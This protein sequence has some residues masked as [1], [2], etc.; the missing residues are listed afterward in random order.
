MQGPEINFSNI[1]AVQESLPTLLSRAEFRE[2]GFIKVLVEY[3]LS[4]EI[5]L[6]CETLEFIL[7]LF[8]DLD[9]PIEFFHSGGMKLLMESDKFVDDE[10]NENEGYDI[11]IYELIDLV[12]DVLQ[13]RGVLEAANSILSSPQ[14]LSHFS[15]QFPNLSNSSSI[16]DTEEN[17]LNIL[18]DDNGVSNDESIDLIL[19]FEPSR[20]EG[21]NHVGF[22]EWPSSFILRS[23]IPSL[24]FFKEQLSHHDNSISNRII[25]DE[26]GECCCEA[27]N[28]RILELGSGVGINGMILGKYLKKP[29]EA[30]GSCH[31]KVI[32][33]DFDEKVLENLKFNVK[34]N[35]LENICEVN[36]FN[37][38]DIEFMNLDFEMRK[39]EEGISNYDVDIVLGSD[40]ICSEHDSTLLA[41]VLSKL[42]VCSKNQDDQEKKFFYG[43][44][45]S[46]KSRFGIENFE[47]D[48]NEHGLNV[49]IEFITKDENEVEYL[50]YRISF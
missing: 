28:L 45:P 6:T 19:R 2:S 38:E 35:E 13:R 25:N 4:K 33:T 46:Q 12:L 26:I 43:I 9:A 11:T 17:S 1:K 24:P 48:C 42:L 21:Q 30:N 8:E 32:L 16:Q 41:L 10:N 29:Q 23:T 49:S 40:I 31:H 36:H 15:Y 34:L 44:F 18:E 37:W 27:N 47:N 22:V 5:P 14:P 7:F 3:I 20:Q 50:L 39:E